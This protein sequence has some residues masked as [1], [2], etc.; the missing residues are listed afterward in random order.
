MLI[1]GLLVIA[2]S[3]A[4]T[5]LPGPPRASAEV[6]PAGQAYRQ[7]KTSALSGNAW[8]VWKCVVSGSG[9][10]E[11]QSVGAASRPV[12]RL[13]LEERQT[14]DRLAYERLTLC[15]GDAMINGVPDPEAQRTCRGVS[16]QETIDDHLTELVAELQLPTPEVMVGPDPSVNKW[17]MA[18]V[19][20]PLWI[21][22]GTASTASISRAYPA[23]TLT[24]RAELEELVFE[25]G[26]GVV[27]RCV[28]PAPY[29]EGVAL[30]TPSPNC[31]HVYQMPS[32]KGQQHTITAT[33]HWVIRWSAGEFSGR[34][35][36]DR[37]STRSLKV[38]ELQS[39]IVR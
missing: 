34:L 28:D 30:A 24:L 20:Y 12:G 22:S 19:G 25:M 7:V 18:V 2:L 1:R 5:F 33:G 32:P 6:C 36:M 10:G 17:N 27:L 29:P 37:T 11:S 23:A 26:D 31:G 3:L 14:R 39:I 16:V 9:G 8:V 13:T 4:F 21:W 38:G 15:L 35:T